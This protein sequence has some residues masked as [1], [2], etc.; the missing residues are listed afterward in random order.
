MENIL[1]PNFFFDFWILINLPF[2]FFGLPTNYKSNIKYH[3]HNILH[4]YIYQS[5][6][7]CAI[8]PNGREALYCSSEVDEQKRAAIG[9]ELR[10]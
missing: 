5:K 9:G 7:L 4:V 8:N 2:Q 10:P 3:I 1:Q 6:I